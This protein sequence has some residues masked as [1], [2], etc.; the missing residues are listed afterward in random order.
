VNGTTTVSLVGVGGQGILLGAAVLAETAMAEGLDVKASEVKGMAQRGGSVLST[1]RFGRHVYSPVAHHADLVF[2][3]EL[4]EGLRGL[5]LLSPRGTLVCATTRI[6]P[7]SVLRGEEAYPQ[8]LA[9]AAADRGVRL[10]LLDAEG[11]AGEAGNLRAV[12][13]VL[14]GAASLVL[15]FSQDAWDRGLAAAVPAKILDVNRR[16]FALGREAGARQEVPR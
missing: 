1:V 13:V 11:L 15:P 3:T 14:L 2:A 8:E 10:M 12:N 16:A 9:G 4:L 5:D 6:L 7:G